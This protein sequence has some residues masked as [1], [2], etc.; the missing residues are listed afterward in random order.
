MGSEYSPQ[1]DVVTGD[2]IGAGFD[3]GKIQALAAE[4]NPSLARQLVEKFL[5]E[6]ARRWE[7]LRTAL[8]SA[9]ADTALREAHTL[10]S[11]CL[12]FGLDAPG[13]ALR[14]LEAQ[15]KAGELP[16]PASLDAIAPSLQQ[17]I[18]ALDAALAALEAQVS[19]A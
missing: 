12:T 6:S 18:A 3:P 1:D 16:A 9:D 13:T 4:L 17:G 7:G 15:L 19:D 8:T 14:T 10:G 2:D 11:A 5:A